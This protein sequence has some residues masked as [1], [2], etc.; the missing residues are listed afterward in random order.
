[1]EGNWLIDQTTCGALA[2]AGGPQAN[3][4]HEPASIHVARKLGSEAG[5][6]AQGILTTSTYLCLLV[7]L[8]L[9]TIDLLQ[10]VADPV[11]LESRKAS[12][13]LPAPLKGSSAST[14]P[15]TASQMPGSGPGSR[16]S[17]EFCPVPH[18]GS[19]SN[20]RTGIGRTCYLPSPGGQQ[21][22]GPSGSA[23]HRGPGATPYMGPAT[24]PFVH[25]TIPNLEK[26]SL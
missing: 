25:L 7:V 22:G 10:Q 12:G 20:A 16:Y 3:H 14:W 21:D 1:M 2:M 18:L 19:G 26:R 13:H 4:S 15:N 9:D 11:H 8:V 6:E 17:W 5:L 23:H 24:T